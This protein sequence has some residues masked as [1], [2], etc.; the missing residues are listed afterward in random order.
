MNF[1][2]ITPQGVISNTKENRI[3]LVSQEGSLELLPNHQNYIALLKE[4]PIFVDR[5]GA[6]CC[7]Y[8]ISNGIL[9]FEN[10]S[11]SCEVVTNFAIN[12]SDAIS[13]KIEGLHNISSNFK[14]QEEIL[15]YEAVKNYLSSKKPINK[16][17]PPATEL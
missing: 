14:C 2:I 8:I 16:N 10:S 12:I 6:L 1:K 4:G 9:Y 11:N 13:L 5:K 3:S 7:F 15:F 17:I